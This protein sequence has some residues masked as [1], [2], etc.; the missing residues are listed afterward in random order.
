[1]SGERPRYQAGDIIGETTEDGGRLIRVLAV[2]REAYFL[3]HLGGL[4]Q[5]EDLADAEPAETAWG[6][7]GC[8]AATYL[9]ERSDPDPVAPDAP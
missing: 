6:I 1:M 2:G 5:F 7:A 4:G 8:E 3:R 9:H